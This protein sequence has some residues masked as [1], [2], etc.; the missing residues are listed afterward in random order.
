[1]NTDDSVFFRYLVCTPDLNAHGTLHG[2]MLLRWIDEATG[3]HAR[4]LTN[5]VNVTRAMNEISFTSKVKIGEIV[6]IETFLKKAGNTSLTFQVNVFEDISSRKI[7]EV[8][9]II[10]VT[11]DQQGNPVPHGVAI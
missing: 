9:E 3:M 11:I 2:G 10:F 7:A 8:K 5:R 4:K 1:M 6:L